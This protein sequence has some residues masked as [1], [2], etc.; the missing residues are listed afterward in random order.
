M[1][2]PRTRTA[3]YKTLVRSRFAYSSQ[4]WSPQSVSLILKVE[5]IQRHATRFILSLPFR[6]ETSYQD[7][8]LKTGLLF[9]WHEYLDLVYLFKA[10]KLNDSQ[11]SIVSN[12]RITRR[13]TTNSVTL[14]ISRV[15]TL[16]FQNS[17]YNPEY[18]T[19]YHHIFEKQ[20]LL[21]AN[22]NLTC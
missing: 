4:V 13:A 11:I 3:L 1:H 22:S 21:S 20:A 19:P 5:K 17:F 16:T 14:K 10:I 15:N 2:D 7:R 12:D 18:I 6:S 8:L 9:Y